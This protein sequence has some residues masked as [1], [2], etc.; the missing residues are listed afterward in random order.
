[1]GVYGRLVYAV[2]R[3]TRELGI[4]L[5]LGAR[6]HTLQALVMR[7][8]VRIAGWSILVGL[9]LTLALAHVA[10]STLYGLSPY[11]PTVFSLAIL[12]LFVMPVGNPCARASRIWVKSHRSSAV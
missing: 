8:G 11:D 3:R 1:M 2:G 5:A 9:P 6:P 4:R 12:A 10:G 7:D